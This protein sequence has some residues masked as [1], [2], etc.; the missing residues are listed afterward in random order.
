MYSILTILN[1]IFL[2]YSIS[3]P[4][5][6]IL[7]NMI[8]WILFWHDPFFYWIHFPYMHFSISSYWIQFPYMHF[9]FNPISFLINMLLLRFS[10]ASIFEWHIFLLNVI[11][12][13]C[14]SILRRVLL[15]SFYNGTQLN[16]LHSFDI[17]ILPPHYFFKKSPFS[18][19]HRFVF[20]CFLFFDLFSFHYL[21]LGLKKQIKEKKEQEKTD[22]PSDVD[23]TSETPSSG[24]GKQK[25]VFSL[26]AKKGTARKP[27]VN[28]AEL[29][30]QKGI[31]YVLL[32][33]IGARVWVARSFFLWC[34]QQRHHISESLLYSISHLIFILFM[35]LHILF[36]T[37]M[38]SGMSSIVISILEIQDQ[39][40][41]LYRSQPIYRYFPSVIYRLYCYDI[42][43][44]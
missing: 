30:V 2:L 22:P 23:S 3:I 7:L 33:F 44:L 10:N 42:S 18:H 29:R 15:N 38:G 28:A 8:Q 37:I 35:V 4:L 20:G 12:I 27:K 39:F 9:L 40:M 5:I 1:G 21:M 25:N 13:E 41:M 11:A 16:R 36:M 32:S 14:H 43:I 24:D 34:I 19:L 26:K 17:S 6:S 31:V